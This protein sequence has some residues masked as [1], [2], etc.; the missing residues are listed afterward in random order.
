MDIETTTYPVD[1]FILCYS[2]GYEDYKGSESHGN[3]GMREGG[4]TC[5]E[6][7]QGT[8]PDEACWEI[9]EGGLV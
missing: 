1:N 4:F 7:G 8:C 2:L 9:P 6:E 3:A 5:L